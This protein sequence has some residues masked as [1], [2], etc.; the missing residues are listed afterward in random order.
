MY[1]SFRFDECQGVRASSKRPRLCSLRYSRFPVK[2]TP[3]S[4]K[5]FVDLHCDYY[6]APERLKFP[7]Y[8]SGFHRRTL[9][10]CEKICLC[11]VRVD[12][13]FRTLSALDSKFHQIWD[14]PIRACEGHIQWRCCWAM[15]V[16][17]RGLT[18]SKVSR[19]E[20]SSFL[21]EWGSII[22]ERSAAN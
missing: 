6:R 3:R 1:I 20:L 13:Y 4:W 16:A 22:H 12:M 21:Y 9:T 5:K 7:V 2:M 14:S 18:V 11:G 17:L 19:E 15:W 10:G 8:M